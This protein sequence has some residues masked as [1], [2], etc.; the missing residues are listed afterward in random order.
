MPAECLKYQK[1]CLHHDG[2]GGGP[3]PFTEETEQCP[4][5]SGDEML[6]VQGHVAWQKELCLGN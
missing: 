5:L 4:V 3:S 2:G 1:Q 6:T